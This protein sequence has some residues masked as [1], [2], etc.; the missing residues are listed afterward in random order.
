MLQL[1]ESLFLFNFLNSAGED[2]GPRGNPHRAFRAAALDA[3]EYSSV[4]PSGPFKNLLLNGLSGLKRFKG[5]I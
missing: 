2:L 1:S 5:L 3:A 4:E